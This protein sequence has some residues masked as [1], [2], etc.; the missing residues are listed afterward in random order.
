MLWARKV[1]LALMIATALVMVAIMIVGA[2]GP[3]T[4]LTG[5]SGETVMQVISGTV[6]IE[7]GFVYVDIVMDAGAGG[8]G[9]VLRSIT[10]TIVNE[11]WTNIP[12]GAP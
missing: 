10:A 1:V 2:Q 7:N 11:T 6:R 5:L 12:R 4:R 8:A 3:V 9:D